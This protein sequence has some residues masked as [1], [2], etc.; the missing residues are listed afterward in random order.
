TAGEVRAIFSKNGGKLAET[1]AGSFM[2]NHVGVVEFGAK[3]ASA[4]A[5]LEAAIEAGG[6]GV[7]SNE[8]GHQIFPTPETIKG[9]GKALGRKIG[10]A[11]QGGAVMEAAEHRRTRRRRRRKDSETD[12]VARRQ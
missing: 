3:G 5:I 10:G 8:E 6:E 2:F 7:T 1:G 9:V 12:R 11:A 4:D